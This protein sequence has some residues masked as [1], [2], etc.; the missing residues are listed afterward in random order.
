[1]NDPKK[2]IMESVIHNNKKDFELAKEL[3]EKKRKE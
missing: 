2:E 1:L 3:D